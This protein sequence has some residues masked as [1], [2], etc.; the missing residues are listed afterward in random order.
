MLSSKH[1][2]L[3]EWPVRVR[4]IGRPRNVNIVDYVLGVPDAREQAAFE[5][6]IESAAS[7]IVALLDEPIERVMNE[8]NRRKA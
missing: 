6:S 2:A 3:R 8:L 5:A 4:G 1:G 7:G